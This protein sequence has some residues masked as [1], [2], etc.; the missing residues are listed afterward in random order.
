MSMRPVTVPTIAVVTRV[1]RPAK[2]LERVL[3]GL[4]KQTGAKLRWSIVTQNKLSAAH[5]DCLVRAT[6]NGIIVTV[7]NAKTG[8][9][10]GELS[11]IGVAAVDSDF[12]IL[13]DDDDNLRS[14]FFGAALKAFNDETIVGVTCHA[15][16]IHESES[17]NRLDFVLSPGAKHVEETALKQD[18]L[19]ATNALIYR[20]SVA[21]TYPE[22]VEVAEDWLFNLALIAQ[23]KIAILPKVCAQ[24]FVRNGAH[25]NTDKNK[26]VNMQDKIR[27]DITSNRQAHNRKLSQRLRRL[28][29]RTTY[30]LGFFLPR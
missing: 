20:R 15:A 8:I 9:P 4:L 28:T 25:T 19:M 22:D 7:S 26:H 1:S 27:G 30:K 2:Y 5:K 10:L 6:A 29:D 13:H 16:Y 24:V 23:G 12:I 3:K 21:L 18:N 14:D 11:N 17:G